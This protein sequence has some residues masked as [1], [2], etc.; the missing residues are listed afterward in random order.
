MASERGLVLA[1][2]L[3]NWRPYSQTQRDFILCSKPVKTACLGRRAGK[4]TSCAIDVVLWA[5]ENPNTI[6]MILA[7]TDQQSTI[8]MEEVRRLLYAIPGLSASVRDIRSAG[9][10]EITFTDGGGLVL[11]TTIMARTVGSD[12]GGLRGLRAHRVIVDE[13]AMIPDSI[14]QAVVLPLLA[15]FGDYPGS[16]LI[17]ISTPRGSNHFRTYYNLGVDPLEPRYASFH[18]PSTDNPYLSKSFLEEQKAKSPE[19]VWAE[20]FLAIFQADVG[21]V[22][23]NVQAA[24]DVGRTQNEPPAAG[25]R[26]YAGF[27]VARMNDFSVLSIVDA[28]GRQ[29]YHDRFQKLTYS[30]QIDRVKVALDR[31]NQAP[32]LID[33]TGVGDA[34]CLMAQK[35]GIRATP[36]VF[37]NKSKT[38]IMDNLAAKIESTAR[39]L[40][41][42]VQTAEL[43]NYAYS[44]T[45]ARNITMSAP[46]GQHDDTVCS[47]ALAYHA[48]SKIRFATAI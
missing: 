20:E 7:P 18:C 11:A 44:M 9:R 1:E 39:L 31:Y 22:F 34:V 14:M 29:V 17:L 12:G 30:T 43:E 2:K 36:F 33:A 5:L 3:W 27:D 25:Q 40:D 41:N 19:R 48:I 6:Q 10:Q 37:G 4:S 46:S 47:L 8:I 21:G 35:A 38:E 32:V 28:S 23:R 15:D 42:K 45:A 26:F 13:A 24:V 16:A